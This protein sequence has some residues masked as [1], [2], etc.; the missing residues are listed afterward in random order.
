MTAI[1]KLIYALTSLGKEDVSISRNFQNR[2]DSLTD[3]ICEGLKE[4]KKIESGK[5][6]FKSARAFLDEL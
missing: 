4:V 6:P 5:Q 1:P 3:R 2:L